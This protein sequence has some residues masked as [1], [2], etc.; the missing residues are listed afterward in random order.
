ME[1]I[2]ERWNQ[3]VSRIQNTIVT[4]SVYGGPA[5][6]REVAPEAL[7]YHADVSLGRGG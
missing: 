3:F 4:C 2:T 6:A 1:P 5:G 7:I